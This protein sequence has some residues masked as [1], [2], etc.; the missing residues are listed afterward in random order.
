MNNTFVTACDSNYLWGAF[1]LII[2]LRYHGVEDPV[3]VMGYDLSDKERDMLQQ[4]D[5]VKVY[6]EGRMTKRSVC[7]QKPDAIFSSNTEFTTWV[8]A[9][10]IVNGNIKNEF[11]ATEPFFHIRFRDFHE[12]GLV[13]RDRYS[14]GEKFGTIPE[15]VLKI[16]KW[17]IRERA[18]PTISTVCETNC[19]I[20]HKSHLPFIKRWKNQ[21]EKVIDENTIGVYNKSS[22]AYFMTDESVLN[23]LFAFADDSPE[24]GV[25]PYDKNMDAKIIHFSLFPKPWQTWSYKNIPFYEMVMQFIHWAR[26]R[27]YELPDLPY[28]FQPANK[29]K[30]MKEAF[31]RE[32]IASVRH[33]ISTKIRRIFLK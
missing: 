14:W 16:W 6:S 29:Q 19:F 8:D 32:L 26:S 12:N 11:V 28:S 24:V 30:I 1:L 13:Y 23:S 4:F 3:H 27:G 9:D 21:M 7:T 17:D 18:F 15:K 2:S 22:T 25:Y 31:I 33:E 10:C 20:I 5:N